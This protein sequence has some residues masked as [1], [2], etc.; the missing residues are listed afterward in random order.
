[1]SEIRGEAKKADLL[2]TLQTRQE[3]LDEYALRGE[4]TGGAFTNVSMIC[5]AITTLLTGGSAFGRSVLSTPVGQRPHFDGLSLA[6]AIGAV[7]SLIATVSTGIYKNAKYEFRVKSAQKWAARLELLQIKF[8]H[9]LIAEKEVIKE[10]ETCDKETDF[11]SRTRIRKIEATIDV[12]ASDGVVSSY[13]QCTG[14]VKGWNKKT[15]LWLAVEGIESSSGAIDLPDGFWPKDGEI[16]PDSGRWSVRIH[17]KGASH[18]FSLGLYV[19]DGQ[20][21]RRMQ[22]WIDFG[23]EHASWQFLRNRRG[24]TR[25]DMKSLRKAEDELLISDLAVVPASNAQTTAV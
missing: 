24:M 7:T 16:V 18:R 9:D 21:H 4:R 5:G 1:M 23:N 22:K 11:V 12:P 3:Q 6:G 8:Q 20:A 2:A 19:A 15:H 17:E 14:S 10:L 13:F 25:L